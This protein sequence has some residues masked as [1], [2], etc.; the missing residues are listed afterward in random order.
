ML[1]YIFVSIT[2]EETFKIFRNEES[3]ES[4]AS[5]SNGV[6]GNAASTSVNEI[7]TSRNENETYAIDFPPLIPSKIPTKISTKIP[8]STSRD[9]ALAI[10]LLFIGITFLLAATRWAF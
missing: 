9:N 10:S 7:E 6:N 2:G 5:P 8:S 1:S 3:S 4:F